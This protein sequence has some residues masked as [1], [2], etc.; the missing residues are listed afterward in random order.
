MKKTTKRIIK[1]IIGCAILSHL[2]PSVLILYVLL[3]GDIDVYGYLVPYVIGLIITVSVALLFGII[4]FAI[5]CL[6]NE[7]NYWFD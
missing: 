6:S 5:W 7:D 1:R 4:M 3:K 2:I